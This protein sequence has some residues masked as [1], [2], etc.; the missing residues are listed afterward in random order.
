[1]LI[2]SHNIWFYLLV[3]EKLLMLLL[4]WHLEKY[5]P[6]RKL[7]SIILFFFFLRYSSI[8]LL[9]RDVELILDW[10]L[11]WNLFSSSQNNLFS[12]IFNYCSYSI[13]IYRRIYLEMKSVF[14][15]FFVCIRGFS[16]SSLVYLYNFLLNIIELFKIILYSFG[17][18]F[19]MIII[20]FSS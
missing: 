10:T 15:F 20:I 13:F 16:V 8:H 12:C 14:F 2:L 19:C 9:F 7:K 5:F 4:Y 18:I 6:C 1:M 3:F 11:I 17:F